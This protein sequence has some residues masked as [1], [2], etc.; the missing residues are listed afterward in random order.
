MDEKEIEYL[1]YVS[2]IQENNEESIKST[3]EKMRQ[4]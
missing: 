2:E 4:K 3:I 1:R